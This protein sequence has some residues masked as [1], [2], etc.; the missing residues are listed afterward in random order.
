MPPSPPRPPRAPRP[1]APPPPP[2]APGALPP[3][4]PR[5]TVEWVMSTSARETDAVMASVAISVSNVQPCWIR[6]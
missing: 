2:P 3:S 5:L 1:I 4:P 6:S